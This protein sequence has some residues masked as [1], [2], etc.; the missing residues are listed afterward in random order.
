MSEKE[1]PPKPVTTTSEAPCKPVRTRKTD[2]G[3]KV[4]YN[5]AQTGHFARDCTN[6]RAEGDA[7]EAIRQE[8]RASRRCFNCGKIGHISSDCPKPAGN[9][10]CYNCGQEGHIAKECPNERKGD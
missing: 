7:R 2:G 8:R 1:E 5:C 3:D 4:C 10:S 6:P 9:K